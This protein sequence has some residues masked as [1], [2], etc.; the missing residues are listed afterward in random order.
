MRKFFL[1]R[2]PF[3]LAMLAGFV[4][5]AVLTETHN[6][7][8]SDAWLMRL[9]FAPN[10]LWFLR[11][12]RL[13]TSAM[14]TFGGRVFWESLVMILLAVGAAEWLTS[15]LR[16]ALTFWSVHLVVLLASSL[17]IVLP[18][19]LWGGAVGNA[20][21][22]ERDVGPSAGYFACLGLV[23][24]F[25]PGR[26]RWISFALILVG[27]F[28]ALFLPPKAGESEP[29]KLLADLAHLLAFPLG[30]LSWQ[31]RSPKVHSKAKELP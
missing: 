27:L 11:I 23:S 16:A 31:I 5:I 20:L 8:L 28:I 19:H 30:W 18:L 29:V 17:L 9:G 10:D 6:A 4:V 1:L 26:W 2:I 15:T 14:V 22:L 25:L 24:A 12:E 7:S 13:F 3:T 21:S